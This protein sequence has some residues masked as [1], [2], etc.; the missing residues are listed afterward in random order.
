MREPLIQFRIVKREKLDDIFIKGS[1]SQ[2]HC[3]AFLDHLFIEGHPL[4]FLAMQQILDGNEADILD[5]M[6]GRKKCTLTE[7]GNIK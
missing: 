7:K 5:Y 1:N 2:S 3:R 4:A 6:D